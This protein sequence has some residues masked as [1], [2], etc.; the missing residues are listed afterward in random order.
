MSRKRKKKRLDE[1]VP[2][3]LI[4]AKI[5]DENLPKD[6]RLHKFIVLGYSRPKDGS[7]KRHKICVPSCS[8]SSKKPKTTTECFIEIDKGVIPKDLFDK[9]TDITLLRIGKPKCVEA[10][11]YDDYVGSL[12]ANPKFWEEICQ[13]VGDF[14]GL[15][16]STFSDVCDCKCLEEENIEL[17]YCS[18]DMYYL[19]N[20]KC[21][22]PINGCCKL[23]SCCG[24]QFDN[25][26]SEFEVCYECND[27]S[28]VIFIEDND[29]NYIL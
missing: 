28:F 27:N 9:E 3:D 17:N 20:Y 12:S 13:K 18:Q 22:D 14:Y 4:E 25:V 29:F 2:G 24:H 23:C 10:Y 16:L 6:K 5:V 19:T 26:I 1:L 8:F 7:G 21:K 15:D 11:F